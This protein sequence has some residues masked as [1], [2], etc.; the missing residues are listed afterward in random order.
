MRSVR[1]SRAWSALHRA[2]AKATAATP[3]II[4]DLAGFAGA[5]FIAY[6]S[7]LIYEPAGFLVGGVLLMAFAMLFGR[8]LDAR[9]E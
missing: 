3:G 7:W 6:G 5:G 8:R 9:K 1:L 2:F 4:C